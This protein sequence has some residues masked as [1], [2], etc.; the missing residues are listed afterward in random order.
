MQQEFVGENPSSST[1]CRR[2]LK[3]SLV[4]LGQKVGVRLLHQPARQHDA[5]AMEPLKCV[6]QCRS[7]SFCENV[8]ANLDDV[9]RSHRQEK[10]V[11]G[12]VVQPASAIPLRTTG[13][14]SGSLSGMIWAASSSSS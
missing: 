2:Q 14:P 10:P 1:P 13:S 6:L 5:L 11:K 4:A 3:K 12:R 7:I 8:G 9:V